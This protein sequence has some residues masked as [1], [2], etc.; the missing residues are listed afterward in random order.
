VKTILFMASIGLAAGVV[1]WMSYAWLIG[2]SNDFEMYRK[3]EPHH[4]H[5]LF[6]DSV[7]GAVAGLSLGLIIVLPRQRRNGKP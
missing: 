2:A 1:W 3:Y 5:Y 4:W 7:G 6:A